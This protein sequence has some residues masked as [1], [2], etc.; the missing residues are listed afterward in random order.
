MG[1]EQNLI[2]SELLPGYL[3][4]YTQLKSLNM[5]LTSNKFHLKSNYQKIMKR[6]TEFE[7]K[8]FSI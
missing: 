3:A 2:D 8:N 5:G 7:D 6:R 1:L 4:L